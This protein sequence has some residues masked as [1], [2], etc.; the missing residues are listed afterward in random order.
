MIYLD[1]AATSYPKPREILQA[2]LE[3]YLAMGVS[4]GRG[5]YDLALEAG[6]AI[7][8][9][10]EKTARFFGASCPERVVFTANAT[11]GLNLAI[12]GLLHGGGH[13]ITTALEHNSVLRPLHA[14]AK[15][16]NLALTVVPF[17]RQGLVQPQDFSN[18]FRLDTRLVILSHASNVLGTIQPVSEV[19]RLCRKQGIP[20]LLDASQSAGRIA[21]HMEE[22]HADALVFTGH[23]S[24]Y[25]PAGIGGLLVSPGLEIQASRFGGTGTRSESL[26]HPL[27]F[28][29]RLEAGTHNLPGILGLG[30]ALDFLE[31]RGLP[32]VFGGYQQLF[33]QLYQ[34][35]AAIDGLEMYTTATSPNVGVISCNIAGADPNDIG[36][37]L[38][39]DYDI[40]VR[41]GVHCAPLVH[42]Q[43]GTINRGAIRF[44]LGL[45]T[46]A[47]EIDKTVTAM[48]EIARHYRR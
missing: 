14:L 45:F 9:V 37:I 39:G 8:S 40:A 28:P 26:E 13:V 15:S 32:H 34:G 7:T 16:K 29:V 23:K 43:L 2:A 17:D 1:N 41:I 46:T 12:D 22:L 27:E 30:R 48:A 10:R 47:G 31:K 19:G 24:L 6:R 44:S 5:S 21:V 42:R 18:A 35:L 25:A 33:V 3:D 4:P 38:D 20:L 36:A 11:D